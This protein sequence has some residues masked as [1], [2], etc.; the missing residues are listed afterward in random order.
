MDLQTKLSELEKAAG[1]RK[2]KDRKSLNDKNSVA[3]I[4]QLPL[5]GDDKRGVPNEIIRS[6]LFNVRNRNTARRDFKDEP[7]MV[8]GDGEITYRGEELRQDDEDVWL[9][10]MHLARLQPLGKQV[11]FTAYS[12]LTALGWATS[13]HG[14][15]RLRRCIRRMQ[16]TSLAI[17]SKRLGQGIS[18]SLIHEFEWEDERGAKLDCWRV[19]ISPKMQQLFG[20]VYY[21][22]LE[23]EQRRQLG[24]IAKKLHGIYG[25][26]A[27][28]YPMKIETI[29]AGCGASAKRL[30]E[31]KGSLI[32]ALDELKEVGFLADWRIDKDLVYVTR[33]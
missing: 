4:I 29:K 5:W 6:A 28:P 16:A 15:N 3:K 14:Y 30:R 33:R 27:A 13:S 17:H 7:I 21:T 20:D 24:P 19:W 32:E 1:N 9:Q 18:V 23:W 8:L 12:M 2:A 11:E 22:Q 25:S 31:F 26:H 10:L